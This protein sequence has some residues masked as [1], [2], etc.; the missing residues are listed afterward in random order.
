MKKQR[1]LLK[2]EEETKEFG[3]QLA[4]HLKPGSVVALIGDLGTGKTTLTQYL[5]MGLGIQE[6]ITSP[7]FTIVKE[8]RSGRIP[9]YHLDVYR[10]EKEDL[11]ELGYDEILHGPEVV[12]IEWADKIWEY[13][14]RDAVV[15][16]MFSGKRPESRIVQIQGMKE[17]VL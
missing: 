7:T 4:N 9:L 3:L 16:H 17:R 5:A 2:N 14:P 13:I 11:W 15:I 12:V 8:Y 6:R 1:Y 10:I